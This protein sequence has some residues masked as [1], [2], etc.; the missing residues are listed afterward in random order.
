MNRYAEKK[1]GVVFSPKISPNLIPRLYRLAK[2]LNI[3]MTRLV[4][5]IVEHGLA[6]LEQ[7]A[8]NVSEA[9]TNAYQRKKRRK[10]GNDGRTS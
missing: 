8:E 3:P 10:E 1:G 7:G 6:R 5:H 4:N 9:S 2:A